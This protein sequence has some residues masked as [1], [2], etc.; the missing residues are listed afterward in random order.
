LTP[1]QRSDLHHA[2]AIV[3]FFVIVGT[4]LVLLHL[5]DI[6]PF[7]AWTWEI[8]GDLWKFC[9]PFGLAFL[10]WMWTDKSG[11]DKR[12]EIEK[13]EAKKLARRSENLSALGLDDRG[14]RKGRKR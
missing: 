13:M 10:W 8:S 3:M 12:R 14:R 1:G 6:G 2:G 5:A 11:L 7:G 9:L 4:L